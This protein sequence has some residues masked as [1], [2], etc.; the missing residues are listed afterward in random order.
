M[1]KISVSN[2]CFRYMGSKS[3]ISILKCLYFCHGFRFTFFMRKS[4]EGFILFRPIYIFC[5]KILKVLYGFQ[6]TYKT[7]IGE[8]FYLGH[9][10]MVIINGATK[11]GRNCNINQ[12]VTI[13]MENRGKRKGTPVIGDKVW[14]GANS[15][16]VGDISIGN[17]VLIA[18]LSFVNF[19]VPDNSIVFGNPAQIK[20]SPCATESYICNLV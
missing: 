15:V 10:G 7:D 9:F 2:D 18:P 13:G 4:R 14:I 6:I 12:G 8:G 17:N 3:I 11:I 16:I 1:K 20:S 19:D 5:Y